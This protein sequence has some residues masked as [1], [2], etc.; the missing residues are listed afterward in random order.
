MI[1]AVTKN[2]ELNSFARF[3]YQKKLIMSGNM[4]KDR[5]VQNGLKALARMSHEEFE[6]LREIIR[7]LSQRR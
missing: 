1:V 5:T 6:G 2:A 3:L 7:I 4:Q